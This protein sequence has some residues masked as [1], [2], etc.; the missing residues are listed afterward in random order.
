MMQAWR[1]AEHRLT[2]SRLADS[3]ERT[4]QLHV[5]DQAML[6]VKQMEQNSQTERTD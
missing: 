5:G 2:L 6:V 4:D 3:L 1:L